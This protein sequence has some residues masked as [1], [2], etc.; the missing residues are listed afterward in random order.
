MLHEGNSVRQHMNLLHQRLGHTNF[1]RVRMLVREIYG[2]KPPTT[3][4]F[5]TACAMAKTTNKSY[6]KV[7][8]HKATRV[9]ERVSADICGPFATQTPHAERYFA[10]FVDDKTRYITVYLLQRKN[11][12]VNVF[13]EYIAEA[14]N[15]HQPH[16]VSIIRTDGGGEM[17]ST[18]FNNLLKIRGIKRETN[19]PYAHGQN[20]I[21][22]RAIR[23]IMESA[24][25]MRQH[26]GL[27][28]TFW[29]YAVKYAA[30]IYNL[31]PKKLDHNKSSRPLAPIEEWQ[32]YKAGSYKQLYIDLRVFGCEVVA[33]KPPE[34]R[35][36][37][38]YRGE[39]ALLLGMASESKAYQLISLTTKR[40]FVAR[41]IVAN[42]LCLPYKNA[43]NLPLLED[44]LLGVKV[45][46]NDG[47]IAQE[48]TESDQ[49]DKEAYQNKEQNEQNAYDEHL[50]DIEAPLLVDPYITRTRSQQQAE[51]ERVNDSLPKSTEQEAQ[52][53]QEQEVATNTIKVEKE[54]QI[55]DLPLL[56]SDSDTEADSDLDTTNEL[57]T[58]SQPHILDQQNALLNSQSISDATQMIDTK[59]QENEPDGPRTKARYQVGDRVNSEFGEATVHEVLP[60]GDIVCIWDYNGQI[61]TIHKSKVWDPSSPSA[62][63][64]RIGDRIETKY[65]G[66]EVT[67]IYHQGDIEAKWDYDGKIALIKGSKVWFPGEP[68]VQYKINGIEIGVSNADEVD[69]LLPRFHHQIHNHP[70]YEQIKEAEDIEYQTLVNM[71]A[72]E[73]PLEIP[74]GHKGLGTTWTYKAKSDPL[75]KLAKIKA[76]LCLRG[77]LQKVDLEFKDAYSPVMNFSSLRV[78]LAIHLDDNPYYWQIDIE[79][80]YLT[81]DVRRETYIRMP[82]GRQIEGQEGKGYRLRKALYGGADSGRCFYDEFSQHHREIGFQGIHQD[83]CYMQFYEGSSYIKMLYHVDDVV[84]VTNDQNLFQWYTNKLGARY[85]YKLSKLEYFLNVKI[86]IHEDKTVLSLKAQR[87]KMIR[88]FKMEE[89]KE[90]VAPVLAG[91]QPTRA[92]LEDK[93]KLVTYP[94]R[95]GNGHL[96]YLAGAV[97]L[98]L[99]YPLKI[100]S[101]F[102]IEHAT[103]HVQWLKHII[104]YMKG[105]YQP[106]IMNKAYNAQDEGLVLYSDSSHAGDPDTRRSISAYVARYKG[107]TIDWKCSFQSMVSHSSTESELMAL[108]AAVRQSQYL[109]WLI[110]GI[111]GVVTRPIPIRVDNQAAVSTAKNPIQPGRNAHMHARYY[112]VRDLVLQGEVRVDK[113][114]TDD[115][116]ADLLCAFKSTAQFRKLAAICKGNDITSPQEIEIV[117]H[118][119]TPNNNFDSDGY[120]SSASRSSSSSPERKPSATV[121]KTTTHNS[122]LSSSTGGESTGTRTTATPGGGGSKSA[123][124]STSRNGRPSSQPPTGGGKGAGTKST[125][126]KAP[127][128]TK[129]NT[130]PGTPT[131]TK[132]KTK[133]STKA[134]KTSLQPKPRPNHKG[135]DIGSDNNS[136][137]SHGSSNS[138]KNGSI[139]GEICG[140]GTNSRLGAREQASEPQQAELNHLEVITQEKLISILR[141]AERNEKAVSA[142]KEDVANAIDNLSEL[143]ATQGRR[144]EALLQNLDNDLKRKID[145]VGEAMQKKESKPTKAQRVGQWSTYDP[146]MTIRQLPDGQQR[147][148]RNIQDQLKK[149]REV[150]DLQPCEHSVKIKRTFVCLHCLDKI[151]CSQECLKDNRR[152]HTCPLFKKYEPEGL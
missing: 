72:W 81:A 135:S 10:I 148:I 30:Y 27:P 43:E 89:A 98:E 129:T 125:A 39:R 61:N 25:S 28:P 70:L 53:G 136:E 110:E 13:L 63:R 71:G 15:Q 103:P 3:D 20:G 64:Y 140:S 29:G 68:P 137:S 42:E 65:G 26:A 117:Q 120:S 66:A 23:T 138:R 12:F 52:S 122:V 107:R 99:S 124:S 80:A 150:C 5:C 74:Q 7:A 128:A 47:V 69:N 38:E 152:A 142:M 22:E 96:Q 131:K 59:Q 46:Y 77:D 133:T 109:A 48:H 37:I 58:E 87:D 130:A 67:K 143:V 9:L 139:G 126:T 17:G 73:G 83:K 75:G 31:L 18:A 36:K 94:Y 111:G 101:K 127:K 113:V 144:A 146:K 104:K 85:K 62:P 8:R 33:Y 19:A 84:I 4:D 119:S 97:H 86:D 92:Q 51:M 112:Y 78:M 82:P 11:Q 2:Q 79:A 116:L 54:E 118:P 106:L 145:E 35:K 102:S 16:R 6:P 44:D 108:D 49:K 100:A 1:N 95:E 32:R 141:K 14:E 132:T 41:T 56:V 134:R 149:D 24:Q 151:Y 123:T 88:F 45:K 21:A 34:T 105:P 57:T 114:S 91:Q 40:F 76:R 121:F 55:P 93:T 50:I 90:A 147:E 115:Q 60:Y